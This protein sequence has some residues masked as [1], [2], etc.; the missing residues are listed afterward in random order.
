MEILIQKKLR[1]WDPY[2]L[3]CFPDDEYDSGAKAIFE[4]TNNK[5]L[6]FDICQIL[7]SSCLKT[8]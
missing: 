3:Y 8:V 7:F 5:S 4:F 2:D 6:T 1:L